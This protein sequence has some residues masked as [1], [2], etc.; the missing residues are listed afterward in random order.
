MKIK[1]VYIICFLCYA[2]FAQTD[3]LETKLKTIP[4]DTTKVKLL[5][6]LARSN[7]NKN[8]KKSLAYLSDAITLSQEINDNIGLSDSYKNLGT[9]HY[10]LSQLDSTKFYWNKSLKLIPADSTAKK[11]DAFNNMGIVYLRIGQTD[12]SL[13]AHNQSL[14]LRK[15]L[16]DSTNVA[17]SYH[18]IAALYRSK[19]DY[20][21]AIEYYFKALPIYKA[22]DLDKETSDLL[23]SVGLLYQNIEN[24]DEALKFLLDSYE[25]RKAIGNPRLIASSINNIGTLYYQ[26]EAYDKAEEYYLKYLDYAEKL[27]DSRGMAGCYL[28]LSNIYKYREENSKSIDY[29]V[30]ANT[31]FEKIKD[32]RSSAFASINL[33]SLYLKLNQYSNAKTYYLEARNKAIQ[34]E[35]KSIEVK[36]LNGLSDAYAGTNDFR[37]ALAYYRVRDSLKE[38]LFNTDLNEK[39]AH[40][41]ELYEAEKKAKEIQILEADTLKKEKEV[42]LYKA[43]RNWAVVFSILLLITIFLIINRNKIKKQYLKNETEKFKLQADLNKKELE[44][45]EAELSSIAMKSLQKN[46]ILTAIEDEVNALKADKHQT[47][48]S[49]FN[50]LEHLVKKGLVMD[51][52]WEVF[53]KHFKNVHPGFF[54]YLNKNFPELTSNDLK[55]CAYVRMNLSSKE[56][57]S[58][59]NVNP[60]SVI[61][62]RYRL[63]KKLQLN[64]EDDLKNFLYDI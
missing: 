49:V 61:M 15:T 3:S 20:N 63:K 9:A 36:A 43:Y 24:Y 51:N 35:S 48:T 12:S 19:G 46:E 44:L 31:L 28:N 50:A 58:L 8:I 45:K 26:I 47:K 2:S 62:H 59:T 57:A 40:Y 56:V 25:L 18:N 42:A 55:A 29:L 38:V 33:G 39:V 5:N 17:R 54:D 4:N 32:L 23:N 52:Q 7:F 10:Y 34:I 22:H 60:K 1:V 14:I 64:K 6:D 21:I 30:K 53:Q 27:K 13:Y 11:A 16:P 37:E 41:Q